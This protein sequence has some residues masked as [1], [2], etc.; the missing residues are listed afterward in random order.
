[1]AP[2][3]FEYQSNEVDFQVGY[4][5]PS[6]TKPNMSSGSFTVTA[7]MI[8]S[9]QD[10]DNRN[11]IGDVHAFT[12]DT[13]YDQKHTAGDLNFAFLGTLVLTVWTPEGTH[14]VT[15]PDMGLAQ[16]HSGSTN[17]WWFGGKN[18]VYAKSNTVLCTGTDQDGKSAKFTIL[19]GDNVSSSLVN[20]MDMVFD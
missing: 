8:S 12:A 18:C 17:N 13:A 10:P 16:G 19:R 15:F 4:I 14:T 7:F 1:M 9:G 3:S 5:R 2:K 11:K 20:I 6:G